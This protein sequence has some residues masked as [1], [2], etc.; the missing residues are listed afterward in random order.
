M[1]L[2][3][4]QNGWIWIVLNIITCGLIIFLL[5]KKLNVYEKGAWYTNWHYWILGIVCGFAPGIIMFLIFN[6]QISI[7][8]SEKLDV[9]GRNIYALPYLWI[10]FVIIPIIGWVSFVI[11]FIYTHIWYLISLFQGKGERYI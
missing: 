5:G 2:L 10:L 11:L 4:K 1:N 6:I 9:P 7:G 8:V 3:K